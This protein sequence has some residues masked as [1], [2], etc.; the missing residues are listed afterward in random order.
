MYA[1]APLKW[2]LPTVS[3]AEVLQPVSSIWMT[4]ATTRFFR[5]NW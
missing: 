4:E 5:K 2:D 1:K 3:S